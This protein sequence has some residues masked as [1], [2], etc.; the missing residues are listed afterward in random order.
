LWPLKGGGPPPP[1]RM[2]RFYLGGLGI[3]SS[4]ELPKFEGLGFFSKVLPKK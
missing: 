4:K 1:P 3:V 2:A